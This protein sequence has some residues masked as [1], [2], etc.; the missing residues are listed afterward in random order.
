MSSVSQ[1]WFVT[2]LLLAHNKKHTDI[3][4][5]HKQVNYLILSLTGNC[6]EKDE[7]FYLVIGSAKTVQLL[8]L[9]D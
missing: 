6:Q 2:C 5:E 8:V 3:E 7:C 4:R 9:M 1:C